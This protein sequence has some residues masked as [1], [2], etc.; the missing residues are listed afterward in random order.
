MRVPIHSLPPPPRCRCRRPFH[1]FPLPSRRSGRRVLLNLPDFS[2]IIKVSQ[3]PEK[4]PSE[5]SCRWRNFPPPLFFT[6]VLELYLTTTTTKIDFPLLAVQRGRR[7]EILVRYDPRRT[8]QTNALRSCLH[9]SH[10]SH[11]QSFQALETNS[12][13]C[14]F[15]F[16]SFFFVELPVAGGVILVPRKKVNVGDFY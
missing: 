12:G 1:F 11:C 6:Q 5:I 3:A 8:A 2:Y 15:F 14:F 10:R 16:F 13:E 9:A 4:F 7:N